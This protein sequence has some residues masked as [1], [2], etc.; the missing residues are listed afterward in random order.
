M[1]THARSR[2]RLPVFTARSGHD[3]LGIYLND[4]L[5]GATVGTE[6]SR[7]LATAC[8]GTEIGDAVTPLAAEIAEDRRSLVKIMRRLDIP[9]RRYKVYAGLL[10][11]RAGRLKSNGALVRRSPLSS[12][13]ELELLRL[14]VQGKA[15]VWGVLR[16]L[17]DRDARLDPRHLDDLLERAR[18]QL[19]IL[20]GLHELQAG[21][22]F[23]PG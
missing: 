8:R 18:R 16:E 12:L 1:H 4:H 17:A 19:R 6:R 2:T 23:S 15:C 14:G 7:H 20:E 11:E 22:S 10:G 21:Q 3:L 5:A 13:L 9:V